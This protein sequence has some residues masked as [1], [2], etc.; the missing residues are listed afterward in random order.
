MH[1]ERYS[2]H[3]WKT[4]GQ[5]SKTQGKNTDKNWSRH[6]LLKIDKTCFVNLAYILA[7]LPIYVI[8]NT[9]TITA[10]TKTVC[11]LVYFQNNMTISVI[12]INI[13]KIRIETLLVHMNN[14]S[15][16]HSIY[17]F[18]YRP[19]RY[20]RSLPVCTFTCIY[21]GSSNGKYRTSILAVPGFFIVIYNQYTFNTMENL[22]N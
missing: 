21:V 8:I 22:I 18:I 17:T 7:K 2:I 15:H 5:S 16:L 10:R 12:H 6:R 4:R 11:N 1:A 14:F 20:R 19:S 9:I 3:K 13:A